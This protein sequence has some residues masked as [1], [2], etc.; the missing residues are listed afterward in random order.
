LGDAL[1]YS[2][3]YHDVVTSVLKQLDADKRSIAVPRRRAS[4]RD[5]LAQVRAALTPRKRCPICQYRE[6]MTGQILFAF[7]EDLPSPELMDA[8]QA[9]EG[10][11]LP[12]LQQT[13]ET[14]TDSSMHEK[15]LSIHREKL[16]KLK[17]ELAEF[18]RK[19]DY[20]AIQ[21]GFGSEG[22]AWLRSIGMI[23]G[24]RKES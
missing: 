15:L 10:L 4:M 14:I 11:C 3:I 5:W 12:H 6:E 1:G 7:M 16:E 22:D 2:I 9:S 24:R 13:L 20:Q 21:K 8:L 23:A 17:T 18:I 19:N